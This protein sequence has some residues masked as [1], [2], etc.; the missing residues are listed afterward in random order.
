MRTESDLFDYIVVGA[1]SAG[2]VLANRLSRNP[3]VRVLLVEAGGADINPWIHIPVGYLYTRGKPSTDW[4]FRTEPERFLGGKSLPYP[5]GRV[6]GGCSSIN[7]MVYTRGHAADYD[8]WEAAG[9]PGWGWHDVVPFFRQTERYTG[10]RS[11]WH[12]TEGEWFVEDRNEPWDIL[13]S[14]RD[15]ASFLGVPRSRDFNSGETFGSGYYQI[16][17]NRGRRSSLATA[18]LRPAKSRRN[19]RII[20]GALVDRIHFD[21]RRATGISFISRG[22]PHTAQATNEIILAAGAIGSPAILQRSG[23][24]DRKHLGTLGISVIADLPGVGAD[25]QDHLQ[26]RI[27]TRVSNTETMNERL[28]SWFHKTMMATEYALFRRGPLAMVPSQLGGFAKSSHAISAP[29]LQF[30]VQMGSMDASGQFH[31]FPAITVAI[32]N[33]Q[34]KS[35]GHVRITSRAPEKAP[36]IVLNYLSD[37]VDRNLL[38]EAVRFVRE[39]WDAPPLKRYCPEEIVPGRTFCSDEDILREGAAVSSAIFHPTSTCRMGKDELSVVDHRLRVHGLAA[40]RIADASIMP[41]ITS[42]NTNAPTVMIAE[43]AAAMILEDRGRT[44]RN[45]TQY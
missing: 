25:L 8:G 36:E 31:D 14:V 30:F 9:N 2:C 5:R 20:T 28:C 11:E 19:L 18:M 40:L 43:K 42:A 6:L 29:D 38:L 17:Q 34:P 45:A 3:D 23:V 12:G 35:R 21:G 10:P 39:L 22:K 32:C 15:A 13:E 1:G 4:C 27:V 41:R 26:T 16:N 37:P 33:L 7:G 24:G 44:G